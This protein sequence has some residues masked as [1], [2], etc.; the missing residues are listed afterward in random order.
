MIVRKSLQKRNP[1]YLINYNR[2]QDAIITALT[3]IKRLI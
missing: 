2:E 3:Q 1:L